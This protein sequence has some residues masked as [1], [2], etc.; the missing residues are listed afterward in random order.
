MHE[1]TIAAIRQVAKSIRKRS[2]AASLRG[3]ADVFLTLPS[4]STGV[5]LKSVSTANQTQWATAALC[6]LDL[7]DDEGIF[8]PKMDS[9]AVVEASLESWAEKHL[10]SI[11]ML[12]GFNLEATL[13][14]T[15]LAYNYETDA[16]DDGVERW[17]IALS[18]NNSEGYFNV[19]DGVEKLEALI[20]GLGHTA[21]STIEAASFRTVPMFSP[22]M[23]FGLANYVYW[24]GTDS[25]D[26]FL[27]EHADLYEGDEDAPAVEDLFTPN[28]FKAS[29]P[30]FMFKN[31][32]QLEIDALQKIALHKNP[33][34]SEVAQTILSIKRQTE[35]GAELPGLQNSGVEAAYFSGHLGWDENDCLNTV[36]DDFY[37]DANNNSDYY[38]ELYGM[39]AIPLTVEK[40]QQWRIEMEKGFALYSTTDRLLQLLFKGE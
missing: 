5:P 9:R 11:K 29:F 31:D 24:H 7:V 10:G 2:S 36:A 38:T 19:K 39:S 6:T 26:D 16:E 32:T 22:G 13:D 33:L 40:F 28:K 21:F 30:D 3:T 14:P 15:N 37:Q 12:A 20:P 17:Y 4:V 18:H 27:A 8:S 35:E 1:R 34:V 23:A 25:E